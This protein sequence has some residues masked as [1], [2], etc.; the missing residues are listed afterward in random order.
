MFQL[1]PYFDEYNSSIFHHFKFKLMI[2]KPLSFFSRILFMMTLMFL[3]LE[4]IAQKPVSTR[5]FERT[6]E[7]EEKIDFIYKNNSRIDKSTGFPIALYQVNFEIPLGSPE[8]MASHYLRQNYK[9]L[10]L[11]HAD[12]RDLRHHFTRTTN[13]GS[14]VR[15]RQYYDGHPV[16]KSELVI[17]IDPNNKVQMVMNSYQSRIDLKDTRATLSEALAIKMANDYIQPQGLNAPITHRLMVYNNN[18]ISRLAY[19]VVINTGAPLGEWH[20]FVDA[21]SGEIFKVQDMAYYYCKHKNH[22]HG[23]DPPKS[24]CNHESKSAV[25]IVNGNGFVFNPDPLSSNMVAYG[26]NYSDNSDATNVDLDAARFNVTLHD[27]LETAGVYQLKGPSAEIVDTESPFNGLFTQSTSVFEFDRL[28]DSFEA[29]NCYYHVDFMMR[30][31]NDTLGCNITPTQYSGGVRIDPS[32]LGGADNS[33]YTSGNGVIAFG[34][35]GVDDAED[36]DVI[37]HEL[38]HG[39]HD[40]V[41]GGNLSQVNGLSEGT[42]DYIAQSYNRSLGNWTPSDPAYQWVFNWDG[43]NPFW[44]GRIT[45]YTATYPGGLTGSIHTDGQIWSTS[46]MAIWDAIGQQEMDKIF[47]EGLGMTGGSSNQDDA[48]NAVYQAA[49]NLNYTMPQLVAI[50]NQF[51]ATGYTLPPLG[52]QAPT[53]DFSASATEICL[54][55]LDTI[56]YMDQSISIPGATAWAWTF[57]GGTPATS[58]AENPTVT[59]TTEGTFDVT[60][61]ITNANG[62]DTISRIDYVST[63]QGGNCPSCLSGSNMT[64]V[65]ISASGAGLTYTSVIII[66][67]GGIITDVN[68]ANITGLHTYLGDLTFS[69]TS[70]DSSIVQL[71]NSECTNQDN[72]NIGFD[73]DAST[74]T[75]ACP[76]NDGTVYIPFQPLSVLNG[77]DA[78]G[79]WTLT[80][81]DDA[82]FDGGELQSWTLEVCIQSASGGCDTDL[83]LTSAASGTYQA[84]NSITSTAIISAPS[85][86]IF[87]AGNFVELQMNFE[88]QL[89]AEFLVEIVPCSP[90]VDPG[91]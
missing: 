47:Y 56:H 29:V 77:Q 65:P 52:G 91:E 30:Y 14:V 87:Q 79:A 60:L 72:F 20:V 69:L 22:D 31:I 50:H 32:G 1:L 39:L 9:A 23:D 83:T 5:A 88:V 13:A 80:I 40:W 71:N 76:Y 44:N 42:G 61:I 19:E 68:V 10:G 35:G 46:C 53:A 74:G 75:L 66:P 33:H 17:S 34:E 43:H 28:S 18:K 3:C 84:S 26:G 11:Y 67:S 27:I 15:Y 85:N 63:F 82:N 38:G 78:A 24:N 73:D 58:T 90:F 8:D 16:N 59:Y 54:D 7:D 86:V 25:A 62:S 48:A 55:N 41:T 21:K 4:L 49:L 89:N 37:H 64:V 36:S 57:E 81:L 2:V 6:L 45:N 70:P 51:T 12:L